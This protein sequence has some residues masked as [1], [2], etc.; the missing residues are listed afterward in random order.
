M[1]SRLAVRGVH[2]DPRECDYD[3][4]TISKP[5]RFSVRTTRSWGSSTSWPC[6]SPT[7]P[8]RLAADTPQF[9]CSPSDFHAGK[10]VLVA[11]LPPGDPANY[12]QFFFEWSTHVAC[13]TN[14]KAEMQKAHYYIAF[15][16]MYV[17]SL[18]RR[19]IIPPACAIPHCILSPRCCPAWHVSAM[20]DWLLLFPVLGDYCCPYP[21]RAVA[22]ISCYVCT[23][24]PR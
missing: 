19:V 15:F 5:T 17:W 20:R 12:C 13:P 7:V 24:V 8:P 9:I 10:P 11:A 14:P 16:A 3:F 18:R 23:S 22:A 1:S 4:V 21:C 6:L 2:R